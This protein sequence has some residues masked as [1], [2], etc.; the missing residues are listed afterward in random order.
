MKKHTKVDCLKLG[1]L[2]LMLGSV[3]CWAVI[4]LTIKHETPYLIIFSLA[5]LFGILGDYYESNLC[6]L[7]A[8][9]CL[10]TCFIGVVRFLYFSGVSV[11]LLVF[12]IG[13]VSFLILDNN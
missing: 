7:I 6:R 9:I 3:Y 4:G 1:I 5:A 10:Y 2:A 12:L 8:Y 13:I 11:G